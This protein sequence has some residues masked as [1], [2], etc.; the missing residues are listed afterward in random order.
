MLFD[1]EFPIEKFDGKNNCADDI[2]DVIK[3][4]QFKDGSALVYLSNKRD[5]NKLI[6]ISWDGGDI[7]FQGRSLILLKRG[8]GTC[9]SWS[10]NTFTPMGQIG[11]GELQTLM[12][13]NELVKMLSINN[14]ICNEIL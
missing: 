12:F 9:C 6:Y 8:N 14:P 3:E 4:V 13:F 7:S 2:F 11:K 1:L 10:S 5:A